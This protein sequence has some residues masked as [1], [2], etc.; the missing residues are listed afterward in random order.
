VTLTGRIRES[1]PTQI[2]G[3]E[4]A[5]IRVTTGAD[6]GHSAVTDYFGFYTIDGLTPGE[7]TI[8]VSADGYVGTSE[9]VAALA[10]TTLNLYLT[11]VARMMTHTSRGSIAAT[12][13]TCSDGVAER[14][15]RIL[16]VPVHNAGPA[17]AVLT[18]TSEGGADLD[19]TLF[20]T[21]QSTSL[22]RSGNVGAGGQPEHVAIALAGAA[23]YEF[24]VTW[25]G[26]SGAADY[27]L[28]VTYPY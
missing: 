13:G 18:W 15:C 12:D 10:D 6:A 19:L 1:A 14:A 16:T 28:E 24:R 23:T 26:G 20:Q 27:V 2:T 4:G 25:A 7:L 8:G 21:G 5:T 3:I 11:P 22:A 17:D 9:R